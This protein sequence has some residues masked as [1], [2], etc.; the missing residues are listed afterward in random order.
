[1]VFKLLTAII[2]ILAAAFMMA[3]GRRTLPRGTARSPARSPARVPPADDLVKC[4]R[5]GL[6]IPAGR[7]CDCAEKIGAGRA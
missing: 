2:V 1:M 6:W 7:R 3:G 4:G 5:C